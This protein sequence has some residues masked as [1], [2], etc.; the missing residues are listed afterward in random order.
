MAD[1][2][3]E[4]DQSFNFGEASVLIVDENN[5]FMDIATQMLSGFGFRKFH[6]CNRLSE[7]KTFAQSHEADLI[8]V[9]PFPRADDG[10]TLIQD[11]RARQAPGSAPRV[12]II[13]TGHTPRELIQKARD[14]GANYV[15]A[16][17]FSPATLL[18]R[19]L[20][21]TG[22]TKEAPGETPVR[23]PLAA[24]ASALLQ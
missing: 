14:V 4:T 22:T 13:M 8:L 9:D 2:C 23:D 21:S 24:A 10:L 15:V 7:S 6:R 3:I 11:L 5:G 16:K 12:V 1:L 18:D 20:W 19:I 17:P